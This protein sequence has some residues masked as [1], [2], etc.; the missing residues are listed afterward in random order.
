LA[1]GG[2]TA[3][4]KTGIGGRTNGQIGGG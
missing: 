1:S 3:G 4:K 2:G